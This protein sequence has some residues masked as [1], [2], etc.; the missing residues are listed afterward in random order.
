MKT[1]KT[2]SFRPTPKE[3]KEIEKIADKQ[4]ISRAKVIE[5]IVHEHL[6]KQSENVNTNEIEKKT[7]LPNPVSEEITE[8]KINVN[9]S[10]ADIPLKETS[11]IET[12]T[13]NQVFHDI[14]IVEL[15][16]EFTESVKL[17]DVS[18]KNNQ[19]QK[20][21]S[22]N[23]NKLIQSGH[24]LDIIPTVVKPRRVCLPSL[25]EINDNSFKT[26]QKEKE[27][28]VNKLIETTQNVD[29]KPTAVRANKKILPPLDDELNEAE[30]EETI[31]CIEAHIRDRSLMAI[32]WGYDFWYIGITK[33]PHIRKQQHKHPLKWRFWKL[34]NSITARE[35]EKH[36]LD[37]GMKGNSG[38]GT[39]TIYIYVF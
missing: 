37:K 25:D 29:V 3:K 32:F 34:E 8:K 17:H 39:D 19:N 28:Q 14:N 2:M 1:Y 22:I 20:D 30:K 35:I 33:R 26:N 10:I 23:V 7:S 13:V 21:E 24:H 27:T 9:I 16:Q 5:T 11:A 15:K 4:G 18:L 31:K 12:T 36:F 6:K 38:G